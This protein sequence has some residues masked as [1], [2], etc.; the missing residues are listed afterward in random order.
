MFRSLIVAAMLVSGAA[1]A[2]PAYDIRS[3][4]GGVQG[5]AP[6]HVHGSEDGTPVIHRPEIPANH[7][8]TAG[9]GSLQGGGDDA[10]VTR[11][12][13]GRGTFGGDRAAIVIGNEDG[14]PVIIR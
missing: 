9:P 13:P 4:P 14:G 11:T 5:N 10:S 6:A 12:G 7:A 3:I 8:V 1:L 2:Q